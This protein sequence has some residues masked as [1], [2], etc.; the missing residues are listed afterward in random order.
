MCIV[1]N[2]GAMRPRRWIQRFRLGEVIEGVFYPVQVL[3]PIATWHG[4]T[5]A[6]QQPGQKG[7]T[8]RGPR[9]RRKRINGTAVWGK[10]AE[11]ERRTKTSQMA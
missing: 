9:S 3:Q 4:G 11:E 2:G 6:A 10:P 7:H 1:A 8:W 5:P